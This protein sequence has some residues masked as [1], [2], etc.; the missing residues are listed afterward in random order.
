MHEDSDASVSDATA[1]AFEADTGVPVGRRSVAAPPVAATVLRLADDRLLAFAEYGRADGVPVVA[2]HGTPGSRLQLTALD[3]P[4]REV[5]VRLIVPDR[6][7]YGASDH[8]PDRTL[9]AWPADVE[10]IA[11]HLGLG[12]FAVLGVS[13]GAPHALACA[14]MSPERITRLGIV[15]GVAPP[16]CWAPSRR[17]GRLEQAVAILMRTGGPALRSL[18]GVVLALIRRATGPALRVYRLL[19]PPADRRI[20]ADP[21]IRRGLQDEIRRQPRT[22]AASIVQD[23]RLFSRPWGFEVGA[24]RVPTDIWHGAADRAIPIEHARAL[25]AR[26]PA[27]SLHEHPDGGHFLLLEEARHILAEVARPTE[28][29]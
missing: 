8:H 27:S 11:D 25:A 21:A 4:A 3:G 26:I 15:S 5:G 7:G 10:A 28:A 24:T 29:A 19:L 9:R 16:D 18:V 17:S 14:V 22:T 20:I 1:R 12:R 6:P 23:L 13:G 2:F